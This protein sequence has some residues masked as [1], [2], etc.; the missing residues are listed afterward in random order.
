M[1][2][3]VC[4]CADMCML[5][6]VLQCTIFNLKFGMHLRSSVVIKYFL[7]L[8]FYFIRNL[9]FLFLYFEPERAPL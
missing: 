8:L 4:G 6:H 3:L 7:N 9:E 1:H 5:M 2:L